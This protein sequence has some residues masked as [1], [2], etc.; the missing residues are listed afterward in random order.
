MGRVTQLVTLHN[1]ATA[2]G[3]GV[4][5]STQ[6]MA[7]LGLQLSGTFVATVYFEGTADDVNWVAVQGANAETGVKSTSAT[8][9]GI[10][11]IPVSGLRQFRARLVWTSGTSITVKACVSEAGDSGLLWDI[12]AVVSGTI[13]EANSADIKT[14]VQVIDNFISGSKGLVTEDNSAS[15]LSAVKTWAVNDLAT[16]G[17]V[18]YVGKEQADGTWYIVKLDETSG[19]AVTH[20]TILNNPT[21]TTYA[22]AWAARATTIS[23]GAYSEAF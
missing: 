16:S 14:A 17:V 7:V 9:S 19:L 15:I 13:T 11:K 21:A 20:A 12:E 1:A 23:Y 8:A 3:N 22:V 5:V 2:S 6:D 18:T 4:Q 10:Y